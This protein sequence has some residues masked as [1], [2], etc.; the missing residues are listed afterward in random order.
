MMSADCIS[1]KSLRAGLSVLEPLLRGDIIT[2]RCDNQGW[3][4]ELAASLLVRNHSRRTLYLHWVDYHKRFWSIDYDYIARLA[5]KEGKDISGIYFQRAFSRD[6]N[7]VE[8]NWRRVA[9]FA[10]FDLLILDSVSEL[11]EERKPDSLPMTYSI[12]KFAQLCI[13]NDCCGIILD[14]STRSIHPY[15]GHVSS[16]ILQFRVD[17]EEIGV[18]LLKHPSMAELSMSIPRN[19]QYKLSRWL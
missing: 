6:N 3:L 16:I 17:R 18:E 15:L 8:E 5:R 19:N 7:E 2:L 9:G 4:F 14:R 12:G 1:P 10:K 13:R 11:Y